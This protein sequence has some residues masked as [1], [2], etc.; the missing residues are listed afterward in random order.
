MALAHLRTC[1]L[2]A[3]CWLRAIA[4][5]GFVLAAFGVFCG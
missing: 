1:V 5:F 3:V 4:D 2:A